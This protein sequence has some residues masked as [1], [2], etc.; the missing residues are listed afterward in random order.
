LVA[1]GVLLLCGCASN[2]N[3]QALAERASIQQYCD[4][5]SIGPEAAIIGSKT[6]VEKVTEFTPSMLSDPSV[7][8]PGEA[9]ALR[10]LDT[11]RAI[12][13]Q[14]LVA[15]GR[16]YQPAEGVIIE[17]QFYKEDV[18]LGELMQRQI[19]YG[20]ANRRIYEAYLQAENGLN[21]E[22]QAY[23]QS[24]REEQMRR[25]AIARAVIANT[26]RVQPPPAPPTVTNCISNVVGSSVYTN[27]H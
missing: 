24:A 7:P 12:C 23:L 27:C 5:A 13:R 9:S 8:T 6:F 15:W 25:L 2:E 19:S 1:A 10:S 16:Q 20:E 18:A 4:S 22:R 21:A 11:R 17:G 26:P 14:R 3:E